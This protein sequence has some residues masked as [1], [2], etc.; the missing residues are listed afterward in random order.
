MSWTEQR[1]KML[2]KINERLTMFYEKETI[3]GHECFKHKS[4]MY[5]RVFE[6]PGSNALCIEYADNKEE[7]HKNRFENGDRFFLE[8]YDKD[9]MLEAMICEINDAYI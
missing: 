9:E 8:D 4:G 7:A 5:F 6:F 1:K 3:S 2:S